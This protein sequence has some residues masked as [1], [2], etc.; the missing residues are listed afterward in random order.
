VRLG[1]WKREQSHDERKFD[2]GDRSRVIGK[3]KPH[4]ED[5]EPR[6]IAGPTLGSSEA[7]AVD[8]GGNHRR[9]VGWRSGLWVA[10]G[11][12]RDLNTAGA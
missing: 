7:P 6:I 5:C 9:G 4:R 3:T 12:W 8:I 10:F 11:P 2:F 1:G